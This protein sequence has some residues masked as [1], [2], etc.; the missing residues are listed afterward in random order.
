MVDR[1]G[2]NFARR[3]RMD[4]WRLHLA[5]VNIFASKMQVYV[6]FSLLV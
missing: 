3:P 5:E 4:R 2:A 1:E 6:M